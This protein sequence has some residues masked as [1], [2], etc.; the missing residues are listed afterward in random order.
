LVFL[1]LISLPTI[2][3]QA[4]H[5]VPES[6]PSA[7]PSNLVSDTAAPAPDKLHHLGGKVQ[8]PVVL[9]SASP[10]YS[11]QAKRAKYSGRVMVYLWV[12]KDG[13]PSHIRVVRGAGMGLDEKAVEAVTQYKFKPATLKGQPVTVDLYVDVDFQIK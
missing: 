4:A 3:Q 6:T 10:K 13:T 9:F 11:Q 2:G 8:N 12:E 7:V 1:A 5:P